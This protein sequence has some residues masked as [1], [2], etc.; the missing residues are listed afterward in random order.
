MHLHLGPGGKRDTLC[1]SV[2]SEGLL[3]WPSSFFFFFFSWP[4]SYVLSQSPLQ[5]RGHDTLIGLDPVTC[6]THEAWIEPH[7][8][9]QGLRLWEQWV[10]R[11][12]MRALS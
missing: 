5:G 8:S 3:A 2:P 9:V 10:P 4:S 7:P 11:G 6:S 12:E 1:V